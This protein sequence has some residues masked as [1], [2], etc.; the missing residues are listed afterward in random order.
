MRALRDYL[1]LLGAS[2]V[3]AVSICCFMFPH[4]FSF[5]GSSGLS[6][7]L[8][9]FIPLS[10]STLTSIL[11][12]L[13]MILAFA[14]LGKRF[15]LRTFFGSAATT[16]FTFLIGLLPGAGGFNT[17]VVAVDLAI[18]VLLIAFGSALMF[19]VGGSSGGTDIIAMIIS[20]RRPGVK[21][22]RALLISD[23]SIILLTFIFLG[24]RSGITSGVGLVM[25][26]ILIDSI[27]KP[28]KMK[29]EQAA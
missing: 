17:G 28:L 27:M 1:I 21:V 12:V 7:V 2:L 16:G 29:K 15:A 22:G 19:T 23:I 13:L 9:R 20:D 6:L 4:A 14:A 3:Y 10:A 5:G 24:V 11:N 26:S 18:A 25:K 8:A